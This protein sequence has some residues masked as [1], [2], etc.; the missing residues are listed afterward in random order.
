MNKNVINQYNK[1]VIKMSQN[2]TYYNNVD[3]KYLEILKQDTKST[4]DF[5]TG[6]VAKKYLPNKI[7]M[8]L[9][10]ATIKSFIGFLDDLGNS[11]PVPVT[12]GD[13]KESF[14]LAVQVAVLLCFY[15][16][17]LI[18]IEVSCEKVGATFEEL[19]YSIQIFKDA[20]IY[21]N[22]INNG[23]ADLMAKPVEKAVLVSNLNTIKRL[24]RDNTKDA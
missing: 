5:M 21:A 17:R 4:Y 2:Q 13:S 1:A 23:F 19:G 20:D 6:D 15:Y 16:N 11:S 12:G 22:I 3:K 10:D 7:E 9:K 18:Q 24:C 14:K 8:F